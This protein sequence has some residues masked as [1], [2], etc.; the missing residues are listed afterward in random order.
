MNAFVT[1]F[2]KTKFWTKKHSPELLIAGGIVMAAGAVVS[3]CFATKK[4]G[5]I[6]PPAT[7]KI[8]NIHANLKDTYK[9]E[10]KQIDPKEEK[11]DLVKVYAKTGGKLLLVY[12]PTVVMF[13]ASVSC[14][15]GSHNIMKGRNLALAAAYT[16][17]DNGYKA[18]RKRVKEKLGE[19]A[20]EAIFKDEKD[21]KKEVVDKNGEL[22]TKNVKTPHITNNADPHTAIY[23]CGNRGWE[24]NAALNYDYLMTQQ[25]WL[26]H[27]LRAQGFLFLSDVYDALGFDVNMLGPDKIRASHIIGWIY[28]PKDPGRDNYVSFGLTDKNNI[29]KSRVAAQI[30]NNEPD[31][32]LEFNDDGDILNLSK[33]PDKKTFSKFAKEGAC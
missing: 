26:N 22:K 31:F 9:I 19:A 28:D 23:A 7:K 2:N 15:L 18:Y 1:A 24:R 33:D 11:K 29:T 32:W 25:A 30:E 6:L 5:E 16:T 8:A 10:N 27:K 21:E 12:A 17:L 3:A 14:I 4:A 13:A 20:E